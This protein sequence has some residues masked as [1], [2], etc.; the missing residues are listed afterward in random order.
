MMGM[1]KHKRSINFN[2]TN[3]TKYLVNI[4]DCGNIMANV[5]ASKA[6]EQLGL[7][8]VYKKVRNGAKTKV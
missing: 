4:Q 2:K 8:R 1:K 5:V 7:T 6:I 3:V